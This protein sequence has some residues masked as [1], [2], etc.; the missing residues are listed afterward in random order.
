MRMEDYFL[1][2]LSKYKSNKVRQEK[3]K[4]NA[5]KKKSLCVFCKGGKMLCGKTRCPIIVK[6]QSMIKH[7]KMNN[8]LQIQGSS[9]PAVF[10]GRIGYPKVHIG[11]MVPSYFGNTEILDTPELWIGKSIDDIIDYRQ[12][13]VR[14]KTIADINEASKG[15]KIV[16]TLQE[17]AMA[18]SSIDSEAQFY[19]KPQGR[20][21]FSNHS[22]PFGPSAPLKNFEI[23]SVKVDRSI[24][25]AFYD[26][27]LKASDAIL[28]LYLNDTLITRIQRSFSIGMFG[29]GT[30]RKLVPTRWSI[31]AVDSTIS[32]S[33]IDK[34]KENETI[35]EYYVYIFNNMGNIFVAILMPE[36]W[37]FEWIEAWFPNTLWNINGQN[38]VLIGDY[39]DYNGRNSYARVG[40]CYYSARLAVAEK[41]LQTRRQASVLVFREILPEYIL[42]VG[43]WN[44]RESMRKALETKPYPFST[45]QESLNF[46]K[47]HLNIPMDNW[48][49]NSEMLKE[50]MFQRKIT[51]FCIRSLR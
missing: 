11:P 4:E 19:K 33:L 29:Q 34:I 8:S 51:D 14:G 18:N 31:T 21:I 15:G 27:D 9:P 1:L 48:I 12:S 20:L 10:V 49:E 3:F 13:L 5:I 43:V 44:V 25:K 41:L 39:E 37:S 22:Q 40:G 6:S 2:G 16:E 35:D 28:D 7:S 38:P 47:S 42:P 30:K 36:K 24:E 17:L 46:A 23:S 45:L 50:V 26:R 32:L